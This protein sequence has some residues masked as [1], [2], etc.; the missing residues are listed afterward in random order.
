MRQIAEQTLLAPPVIYQREQTIRFHSSAL[1]FGVWSNKLT[2]VVEIKLLDCIPK[3]THRLADLKMGW[4]HY[5]W[6]A[7]LYKMK[8]SAQQA[9]LQFG[10]IGLRKEKPRKFT[11]KLPTKPTNKPTTTK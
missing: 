11:Q 8:A 6:Q 3:T 1:F 10:L 7:M 9:S 4:T 2:S 5:I